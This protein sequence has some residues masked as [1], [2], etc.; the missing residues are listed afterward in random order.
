MREDFQL[1]KEQILADKITEKLIQNPYFHVLIGNEFLK[2]NQRRNYDNAIEEYSKAI[3]LDEYFQLNAFY[4]RGYARIARYGDNIKHEEIHN[5]IQDFKQA[6]KIIEQ[7][8]EPLLSVI[9]QAATDSEALSEQVSHKM[10]LYGVQKNSIEIAIGQD[11]TSQIRVLENEKQEEKQTIER[12]MKEIDNQL[13]QLNT[14]SLTGEQQNLVQQ[15][16][17]Q[18][19]KE[20]KEQKDKMTQRQKDIDKQI[21]NLKQNQETKELGIIGQAKKSDRSIEIESVE[22]EKSLPEDEDVR[23]YNDEIQEYKANGFRGTFKIKEIKP[24]D[25]KS[26]ISVAAL[27]IAQLVGGAAIAVFSLGAGASIGMGLIFEGVSDLIT[28]VKDGIINRDF[29]WVSYGIQKAISLTVSLVCAGMGA[30][31]DAAKTVVAGA[32]QAASL[33][34]KTVVTTVTK[35]GWKIA[36]KAIGTNLAKGVAKELVTQLVDYGVNKALM[37][38][39]EIEVMKLIEKPIQEALMKNDNVKKMLQ[40]D[41]IKRKRVFEMLIKNKA[42]EIL[43]PQQN[44]QNHPLR[45]IAEGVAKGIASNKIPGLSN[46]MQIK[47][48]VEALNQLKSFVPEFLQKL[49]QEIEKIFDDEDVQGILD[50]IQQEQQ[51][52][53]KGKTTSTQQ[54]RDSEFKEENRITENSQIITTSDYHAAAEENDDIDTNQNNE[55][56]QQAELQIVNKSPD[57]LCQGLTANVSTNMCN[58]IK[59]KLITPVTRVGINYQMNNLTAGLDKSLQDEIGLFQ[60]ER[61]I[62]FFQ[63]GDKHNRIPDEYKTDKRNEEALNKVDSMIDEIKNGGEAGLP[64]LG[65]ASEAVGRPIKVFDEKGNLVRV[66]GEDRGGTPLEIEYHKATD[67]NKPGHWTLRGNIEPP[68]NGGNNDCFFNVIGAQT[69]QD[70]TILRAKIA[71]TMQNNKENLANQANDIHILEKYKRDALTLGGNP[72]FQKGYG[73][74][75]IEDSQG[76]KG[77]KGTQAGHPKH[78]IEANKGDNASTKKLLSVFSKTKNM[79]KSLNDLMDDHAD[80]AQQIYTSDN[81]PILAELTADVKNIVVTAPIHKSS[82]VMYMNEYQSVNPNISIINQLNRA[83]VPIQ[84][85]QFIFFSGKNQRS[86]G[87]DVHAPVH[88]QTIIP[89]ADPIAQTTMTINKIDKTSVRKTWDPNTKTFQ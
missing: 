49:D 64:H 35:A 84:S 81:H 2:T 60:A 38:S 20:K 10:T 18:L 33:L 13:T 41:Q 53:N 25:W 83:K 76:K 8:F 32:K 67:E 61:R 68:V 51:T 69:G 89:R 37:P 6:K 26:V 46:V 9:Q 23:L 17:N 88:V 1:F 86:G 71:T 22:I 82:R 3:K 44:D 65:A 15:Q 62:E 14:Q 72:Q 55:Q 5:A 29:S 30:I 56:E 74:S 66:I 48:A 28:A 4:N 85:N 34:T 27:G 24:I 57:E 45:T 79:K 63:N 75:I 19:E 16:I 70:P 78:H 59:G 87:Y 40:L 50:E 11:I 21:E 52:V 58:I 43:Y 80:Q 77:Y 39:I 47:E 42:F 31:K 7:H 12:R 36:A 73:R 54:Q